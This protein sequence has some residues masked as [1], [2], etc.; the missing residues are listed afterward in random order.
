MLAA[1]VFNS[2]GDSLPVVA[3]LH[4]S[5][6]TTASGAVLAVFYPGVDGRLLYVGIAVVA[7]LLIAT[8]RGR[9]GYQGEA[10]AS[11]PPLSPEPVPTSA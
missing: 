2:T 10:V 3:L 7:V 4:A 5:I 9:L 1:G 6:D 11:P 8:T